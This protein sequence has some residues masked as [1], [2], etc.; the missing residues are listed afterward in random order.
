MQL[1]SDNEKAFLLI[2]FNLYY[3]TDLL[4]MDAAARPWKP[5]LSTHLS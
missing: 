4:H 2:Y 1:Y 3:G 5:T